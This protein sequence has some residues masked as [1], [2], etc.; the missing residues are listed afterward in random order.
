MT[1][2]DFG[3]DIHGSGRRGIGDP[4]DIF[5]GQV[6]G[7][8][9]VGTTDNYPVVFYIK[10][11]DE[12]RLA[13]GDAKTLAL[14]DGVEGNAFVVSQHL[15]VLMDDFARLQTAGVVSFDEGMIIVVRDEAD[16]LT[17]FFLGYRRSRASFSASSRT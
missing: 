10:G 9:A 15:S 17:F 13:V 16:F 11:L 5:G 6:L 8:Y 7:E 12:K 1:V 14:T 2:T 4:V 3:H